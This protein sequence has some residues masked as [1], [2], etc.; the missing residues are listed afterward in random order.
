VEELP[1][2]H[3]QQLPRVY[4]QDRPPKTKPPTGNRRSNKERADTSNPRPYGG[5]SELKQPETGPMTRRDDLSTTTPNAHCWKHMQAK[6]IVQDPVKKQQETDHQYLK[7][8]RYGYPEILYTV[9]PTVT[10]MK[11]YRRRF[12][13][14]V[15]KTWND[16]IAIEN[17]RLGIRSLR[18]F[19]AGHHRYRSANVKTKRGEH[20]NT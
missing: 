3:G 19:P 13:I 11:L 5:R 8:C 17:G 6:K 16:D 9:G 2:A 14:S 1:C 18:P 20:E 7:N 10:C 4:R 15:L 12:G